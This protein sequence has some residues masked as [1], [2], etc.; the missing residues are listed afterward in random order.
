MNGRFEMGDK[1]QKDKDKNQKQKKAKDDQKAKK[2]LE[3][4]PGEI[5]WQKKK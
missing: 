5:P 2:K 4:Q 3:K 1:G